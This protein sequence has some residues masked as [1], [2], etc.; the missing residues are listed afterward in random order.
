[1]PLRVRAMA[2]LLCAVLLV[3]LSVPRAALAT[4]NQW[5]HCNFSNLAAEQSTAH[6]YEGVFGWMYT[7]Q[8]AVP[9][10][11]NSFSLSHLFVFTNNRNSFVEVG[12]YK[13]YGL[14]GNA[15]VSSYYT[16]FQD[17][18]TP[19]DEYNYGPA[20][21]A[22]FV[23]YETQ[24]EG[25]DPGNF[26]YIWRVYANSLTTPLYSWTNKDLSLA[27]ITSGGEISARFPAT[28]SGLA[29][30]VRIQ[31][32]H[33]IRLNNAW[34]SWTDAFMAQQGDTTST[35]ND[36]PFSLTYYTRF[37]DYSITGVR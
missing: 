23:P 17:S 1:M 18:V 26:K 5:S 25:V 34:N 3:G 13:G 12:W 24:Y 31:P 27:I 19:Y 6:F 36:D 29:M 4:H 2:V 8:P 14:R 9:N 16:A 28:Y 21:D 33:Q 7:Y 35:C 22:T 11:S 15:T 20:P 30:A 10:I 37:D 32:S